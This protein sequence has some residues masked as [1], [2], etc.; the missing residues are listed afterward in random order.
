[1]KS[2]FRFRTGEL[3]QVESFNNLERID[4]HFLNNDFTKSELVSSI[5]KKDLIEEA[6][7]NTDVEYHTH[8]REVYVR[9]KS[10][11]LN[12]LSDKLKKEIE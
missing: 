7:F 4:T 6:T 11:L 12:D 3:F 9:A 2:I 5:N 8:I 10:V 1:M